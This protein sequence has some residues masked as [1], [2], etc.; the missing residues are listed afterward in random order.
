[1]HSAVA[2]FWVVICKIALLASGTSLR[3]HYPLFGNPGANNQD[4]SRQKVPYPMF[5]QNKNITTTG[6]P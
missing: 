5:D 2:R 1:M 3:M 4:F 6:S